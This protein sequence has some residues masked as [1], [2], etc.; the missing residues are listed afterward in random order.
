MANF[1]NAINRRSVLASFGLLTIGSI[2]QAQFANAEDPTTIYKVL[3]KNFLVDSVPI[4]APAVSNIDEARLIMAM[5]GMRTVER[6]RE[7]VRQNENPIPL[8]WECAGIAE[9]RHPDFA[10][11]LYDAVSDVEIV[12]LELKKRFNRPRPS[13]VLPAIDPVVAVP[14]HAAYPSGHATQSTVIA[15]LLS[16]VVPEAAVRLKQLAVQVGRNREI[17]G[18]HYPSDTDAG[19]AVGKWLTRT[20]YFRDDFLLQ[21]L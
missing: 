18:L 4:V 14:W 1:E 3:P 2:A 20:S 7:I 5:K 8:F 16:R 10:S 12:V 11:R 13:S 15:E 9:D 21:T 19:I 17:A 6:V